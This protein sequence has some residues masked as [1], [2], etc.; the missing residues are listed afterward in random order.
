MSSI[1][2]YVFWT[3]AL[4]TSLVVNLATI[5]PI[6]RIKK[7]PGTWGSVVGLVFYAVF[8]H[9]AS[10]L[11]F[12]FLAGL[13]AYLA[14]AICDAAE[15]RLQMRDPGMIVLDEVVAVPLVFV[16]MGGHSGLIAQHGSWPVLLAG[17]AL[18]RVFDILK[19]FGISKLQDLPGGLGC[20]VDDLAAG[21]AACVTLHMLLY[22]LF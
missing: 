11:G 5:G 13:S 7:A 4:S 2:R 8:F 1:D 19:P 12:I 17:F 14:I 18:F 15:K 6:G 9:H 10:P 16:G 3:R 21:L 22:F 20:A